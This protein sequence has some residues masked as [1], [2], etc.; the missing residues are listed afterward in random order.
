MYVLK[1]D[2]GLTFVEIGNILGGRDHTTVMHG[3]TKVEKMIDDGG[4][5]QELLGI[6]NYEGGK[7]AGY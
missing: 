4:F 2:L 5:S 3:V 1:K 6:K 7:L